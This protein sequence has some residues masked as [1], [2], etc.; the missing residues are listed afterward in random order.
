VY[1]FGAGREIYLVIYIMYS[2]DWIEII[3]KAALFMGVCFGVIYLLEVID[4]D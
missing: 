1:T 4:K 3:L 2:M